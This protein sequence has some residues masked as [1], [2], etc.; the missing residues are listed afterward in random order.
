MHGSD[1]A[2]PSEALPGLPLDVIVTHVLSRKNLPD[3]A[4]LAR[5]RVVSHAMRDAVTMRG[6]KVAELEAWE[7]A[8][9]GCLDSLLRLRRRGPLLD[10]GGVCSAA[11]SA[12]H[13]EVLKSARAMD[14]PWDQGYGSTC[15]SAARAG[16]LEIIKWARAHGALLALPQL[17]LRI[18]ALRGAE[19][20]ACERLPV[21]LKHVPVR[22]AA[23][24]PRDAEMGTRERVPVG[25]AD[26]RVIGEGRALRGAAVGARE[27]RT[28]E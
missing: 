23:R 3:P 26:V 24:A 2:T 10:A 14:C 11:A 8:E 1:I 27:R 28:V 12:G 15:V 7:Y 6:R 21:G 5:L 25:Q 22:G 4:D 17:A 16:H 9:L 19:V 18:W 20:A 13:L